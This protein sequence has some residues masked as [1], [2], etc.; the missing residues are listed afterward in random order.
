MY[1]ITDKDTFEHVKNWMAD[2][3]KFAKE[4]VLRILVGNKCDLDSKRQVPFDSGKELADKYG[5]KFMET[6]AK[7]TVN[8]EQLFVDTTR[9]FMQK[10]GGSTLGGKGKTTIGAGTGINLNEDN[11]TKNEGT[12][13]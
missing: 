13:C 10:Q 12:C 5:I 9:T 7:E 3:D 2:V 4:G 8:I 1:D 11:T 6:S